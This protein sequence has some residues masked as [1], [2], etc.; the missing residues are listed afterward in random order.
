MSL[1]RK[2]WQEGCPRQSPRGD[3][4]APSLGNNTQFRG[5]GA[6][7]VISSWEMGGAR[8]HRAFDAGS[9]V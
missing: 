8:P 4:G 6:A 5:A 1:D 2:G 3:N 7:S 9:R